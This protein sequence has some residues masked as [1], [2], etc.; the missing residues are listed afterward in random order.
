MAPLIKP[1]GILA[2]GAAA[3]DLLLDLD[4][5]VLDT[6]PT[7]PALTTYTR[8]SYAYPETSYEAGFGLRT[9]AYANNVMAFGY[10]ANF[11]HASK[12]GVLIEAAATNLCTYSEQFDHANWTA[13]SITV[14]ANDEEAPDGTNTADKLAATAANGTLESTAMTVTSAADYTASVYIKRS[15]AMGGNVT[16]RLIHYDATGAAEETAVAFTATDEWQRID[17]RDASAASTS[18]TIRIEIDTNTEEVVVWGAQLE[19]DYLTSYIPTTSA[20]ATRALVRAQLAITAGD[21]MQSAQGEMET[22]WSAPITGR[23]GV[24]MLGEAETSVA[25][26][27]RHQ[28]RLTSA[29]APS[30][31]IWDSTGTNQ[32]NESAAATLDPDAEHT[33]RYRWDSADDIPGHAGVN[34]DFVT[35][36][37]QEDGALATTWTAGA[38]TLLAIEGIS[39]TK[40][41]TRSVARFR[42]WDAPR[43]DE[44]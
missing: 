33:S 19:A 44:P 23:T 29:S 39:A 35:D 22:V 11:S 16:G 30:H 13:T 3:A 26:R 31:A 38:S 2:G 34:T 43:A 6:P 10:D 5:R 17:V 28:W 9:S 41:I 18:R 25:N 36:G 1:C 14:T 8:A 4:F 12:V 27:D 32:V 40:V 24:W 21:Y 7:T 37:A 20:A 42:I 15:A